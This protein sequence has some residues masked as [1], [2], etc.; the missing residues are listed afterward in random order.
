[1]KEKLY[2]RKALL[3]LIVS[4]LFLLTAWPARA[5]I[6]VQ[7]PAGRLEDSWARA[8]AIGRFHFETATQHTIHPTAHPAN[9]GRRSRSE[10]FDI[11]GDIDEPANAVTLQIWPHGRSR[12]Q[13]L[14]LKQENGRTL[15][16]ASEDEEWREVPDAADLFLQSSQPASYLT[17]A[18]NVRMLSDADENSLFPSE[19]LPEELDAAVT[20][21]RFDLDG[22]AYARTMRS[23]M[24]DE[25]RRN[26]E[27]PPGVSLGMVQQFVDMTGEGELW[28]DARGLPFRQIV[29]VQFPADDNALEWTDAVITTAYSDWQPHVLDLTALDWQ[30]PADAL[31]SVMMTFCSASADGAHGSFARQ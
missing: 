11:A 2:R 7:S 17:A 19:L 31:A 9:I 28:L 29:R 21:Y 4:A 27:L 8:R 14:S 20:R 25:L 13:S 10:Q 6:T 12:G 22:L 1:M 3:L 23:I 30:R 18:K 5:F 16:R 24:E 15:G 26:G